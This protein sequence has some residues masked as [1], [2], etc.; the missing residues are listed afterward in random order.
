MVAFEGK[1]KFAAVFG[2]K[3]GERNGQV[4]AEGYVPAA[5]I[6]KAVHLAFRFPAALSQQYFGVFQRRRVYRD[7]AEGTERRLDFFHQK[8]AGTFLGGEKIPKTLEYSWFYHFWAWE[9]LP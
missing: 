3:T 9:G 1:G 4:K 7:K 5:V 6:G 8:A 2:D